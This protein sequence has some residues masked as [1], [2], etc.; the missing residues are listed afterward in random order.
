MSGTTGTVRI[1]AIPHAVSAG[2]LRRGSRQ[3]RTALHLVR[4]SGG[5]PSVVAL[6]VAVVITGVVTWAVMWIAS[7]WIPVP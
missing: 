3:V 4:R 2:R 1:T 5:L 6:P 7:A